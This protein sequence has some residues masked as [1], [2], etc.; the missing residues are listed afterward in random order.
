MMLLS[1]AIIS[2]ASFAQKIDA[3]KVP[4]DVNSAFKAKFKNATNTSW[5]MENT[6]EF[7]ADFKLNGEKVSACFDNTGKWLET[8][9]EI[10][11]SELPAL[12]KATL[13]TDFEGY[14]IIE[15]SKVE[16]AKNG[17]C[18][19]AEVEKGEE[20]IDVLITAEGKILSKT[21]ENDEK[22]DKEKKD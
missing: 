10:K 8:E 11:V 5:E 19:E 3:Q 14:K 20:S 16:S 21:I 13:N 6:N 22:E 12:V 2:N 15:A 17:K 9:T 1:A 18:F 4:A 7:E